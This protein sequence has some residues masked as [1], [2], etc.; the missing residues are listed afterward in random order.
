MELKQ[1]AIVL[2]PFHT[3]TARR[4]CVALIENKSIFPSCIS[5]DGFDSKLKK[6]NEESMMSSLESVIYLKQWDGMIPKHK[7]LELE[8]TAFDEASPELFEKD[9]E[10]LGNAVKETS[11]KKWQGFA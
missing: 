9:L 1:L 3:E 4:L 7:L 11:N 8:N 2:R 6:S 10:R 5:F